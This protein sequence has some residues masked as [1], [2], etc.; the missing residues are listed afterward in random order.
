M[1]NPDTVMARSMDVAP[2]MVFFVVY[3]L[4][5]NTVRKLTMNNNDNLVGTYLRH[6]PMLHAADIYHDWARFVTPTPIG[7]QPHEQQERALQRQWGAAVSA[8]RCLI[9]AH[10]YQ[11]NSFSLVLDLHN[12][13]QQERALQRQQVRR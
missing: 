9:A 10:C 12:H 6:A 4:A 8:F 1:G 5:T 7:L 3:D 13:E 11:M 2:V